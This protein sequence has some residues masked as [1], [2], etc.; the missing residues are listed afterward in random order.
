MPDEPRYIEFSPDHPGEVLA[1]MADIAD[2]HQG[3]VNFE[4][5]VHVEDAPVADT[6]VFS[7]FSGRGP[8]VPLGTWTP[9]SAPGRGRR[10]P[11][12]IG[13]QHGAGAKVKVRL[14][15]MG[16]PVP[17]GWVVVQDHAKKGLVVALPP[18]ADPAEAVR[19]LVDAAARLSPVPLTGWRAAVF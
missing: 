2:R 6:G 17:E 15:E 8:T 1:V 18:T 5:S 10:E 14:A 9:E 12:M 3:W 11:A 19:W 4:P 16:H 13:L 7:L